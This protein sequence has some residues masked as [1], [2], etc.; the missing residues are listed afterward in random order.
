M[1]ELNMNVIRDFYFMLWE[2]S[3]FVLMS[4]K[5]IAKD[6]AKEVDFNKGYFEKPYHSCISYCF[7]LSHN[8]FL[9][10][11]KTYKALTVMTY[12]LKGSS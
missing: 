10:Q 3:V 9:L 4:G 7:R 11:N 8:K 12:L 1:T 5:N 6:S 2:K